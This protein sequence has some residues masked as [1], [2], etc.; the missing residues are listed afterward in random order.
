MSSNRFSRRSFLLCIILSA[1]AVVMIAGLPRPALA[2]E[3]GDQ[4]DAAR[5]QYASGEL[6]EAVRTLQFAIARIQ[7]KIDLDLTKLL[8]EPL[9]GWEADPPESQTAG[10]ATLIAG[11]NLSRR[12]FRDDGA[13]VEISI[14]ADSPFL[15]MFTTMLSNPMLMQMNPDAR[16][17]S[18]AEHTG[19]LQHQQGSDDWEVSLLVV[20]KVLLKVA[21]SG[22]KD[23]E[24]VEEYLKAIDLNALEKVFG[25]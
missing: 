25:A 11:T 16:I 17:Y 5:D 2:D 4:L 13:Q 10:M 24:P 9:P 3:I 18:H 1:A 19:M 23:A 14:M 22:L 7:E 20:N 15:P 12:Y 21:G 6:R 8:P